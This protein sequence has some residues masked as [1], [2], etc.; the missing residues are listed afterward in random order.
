RENQANMFQALINTMARYPGLVNGI[1]W[2]ENWV[3]S[4][5]LWAEY[6]AGRRHWSVRDK[7]SEDVVRSVHE[8]WADWMTGGYWMLVDE[9]A[10]VTDVGAYVDGPELAGAPTLPSLGTA[11]YQGFAT[12]G[13]AAVYGA[14]F[15][16]VT[17]GSHEVGEYEGQLELT[18]DFGARRISG[19]VHSISLS[20]IHT[21]PGGSSR[22]ITDVAAPYVFSLGETRFD[23]SGFTGNTTVTS[24]DPGISVESSTGSWGGKFSVV[25][26]GDGNPRLVAGTHGEEFTTTGGTEAGFI[27]AFVGVTNQ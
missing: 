12:G 10:E 24:T 26:D 22:P 18:A 16:N 20:G 9:N 1:L 5:E 27:G 8:S 14:D 6:W 2:T 21:P 23:T 7:L 25:S 17:A 3:A 11:T 15:P 4:D 19:R 13:Y